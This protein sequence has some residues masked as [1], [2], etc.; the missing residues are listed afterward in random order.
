MDGE[1][2]GAAILF[3]CFSII[4]TAEN[5]NID[6]ITSKV[7]ERVEANHRLDS[8]NIF[9]FMSLL[10][11]VILTIWLF[12][13]KRFRFVHETGLAVIYGLIIGAIIRYASP[14]VV[15]KPPVIDLPLASNYTAGDPPEVVKV[16]IHDET[17]V[18]STIQFRYQFRDIVQTE[19][20]EY[21]EEEL[22]QKA[23]FDPEVF[24]NVLLPPIIFHAGYSLKRRHF[25]RNFGAIV[26]YAFL[27]TTI[28]T[29][30]IGC[31]LYGITRV[32][33]Y[34]NLTF[35]DTLFF[36]AL[37]SATDPVTVLAIFHDL[38]V[39]VDLYALV[40]GESVLNDAVAIVLSGSVEKYGKSTTGATFDAK[41]FFESLGNFLETTLFFLVSYSTYLAADAAGLTG[42]VAI[43][44]CGISQAH[45]TYNN[46]SSESKLRTK[47]LFELLNMLA[48][49]F[50]FLYIG[51][52]TFT[53]TKHNWRVEF[54][55]SAF[56]AIIVGRAL[57][58]YPISFLLN[59]GRK[60]KINYNFQHLM[61]FSGL[62]GAIAF[63][64]A[65]R[66]TSSSVRQ[67]LLST[68]LVIVIAT[69]IGCGGFTTQMLQWLKIRVGVTDDTDTHN[70]TTAVRNDLERQRNYRAIQEGRTGGDRSN[71]SSENTSSPVGSP[72]ETSEAST[73]TSQSVE[74]VKSAYLIDKW[75]DFDRKYMKPLFTHSRPL[76]TETLPGCCLPLARLLTTDRQLASD[77]HRTTGEDDL[78]III[79]DNELT[80][81]EQ[82]SASIHDPTQKAT[83]QVEVHSNPPGAQSTTDDCQL[84]TISS[85]SSSDDVLLTA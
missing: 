40:F 3:A 32:M 13:Y 46:L 80:Y 45:Y 41:A 74:P 50:V 8:Q 71:M 44:F 31:V 57:N 38:H 67:L 68:T 48:E 17:N 53:F 24:F 22:V 64:L 28:S 39:D 7:E 6:K 52:S 85:P 19:E 79:D 27:G 78:E 34:L 43:L 20:A 60:N 62:R 49:N 37:I 25:F 47:Q 70:E 84:L 29:L 14:K 1:I 81:G 82:S 76:L 23:T 77:P 59:L 35:T 5:A 36:G 69:V 2:F 4:L 58:I 11:L 55:F 15:L 16:S 10:I 12:K 51:V 63:A 30:A 65:I 42:I 66:N 72:S 83:L 21:Q 18:N 61:M 56:L 75:S 33:P 73:P 9:M 54:I 26:G